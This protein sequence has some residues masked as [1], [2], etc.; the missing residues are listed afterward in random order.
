VT[1]FKPIYSASDLPRVG[2]GFERTTLDLKGGLDLAKTANMAIDVAAFANHWGGT[3]LVGASE[4]DGRIGAYV[5]ATEAESNVRKDAFSKA[6]AKRCRPSPR[7][8]FEQIPH[9]G[10]WVLAINVWP[11]VN[12]MVG[13]QVCD[14]DAL[15]ETYKARFIAAGKPDAEAQRLAKV[16]ARRDAGGYGG[17]SWVFPHRSGSDAFYVTPENLPMY[18]VPQVRRIALLLRRI[19]VGAQVKC[20]VIENNQAVPRVLESV[21]EEANVVKLRSPTS[22]GAPHWV[23]LDGITSTFETE[24]GEWWL[25]F[26]KKDQFFRRG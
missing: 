18:M 5:P 3:I 17:E 8:D 20:I 24:Q 4:T 21:D 14:V 13:V 2:D 9:E 11:Q 16:E 25:L 23:P 19:P 15:A 6:V 1:A 12:G 10:G 7:V 22:D 26:E